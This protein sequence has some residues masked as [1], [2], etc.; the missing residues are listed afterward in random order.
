MATLFIESSAVTTRLKAVPAVA[1][2]GALTERCV[3]GGPLTLIEFE[4]P[5][6]EAV[7]VSVAVMVWFPM[8][9]SVAENVPVPFFSVELLGIPP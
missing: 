6:I 9:R 1:V 3:A 2:A 4:L 7:T 8:F 5:E